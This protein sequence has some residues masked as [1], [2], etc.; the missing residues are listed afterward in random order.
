MPKVLMC[1]TS[2]GKSTSLSP[3]LALALGAALEQPQKTGEQMAE[4]F[5]QGMLK[6]RPTD[7]YDPI[8]ARRAPQHSRSKYMPH[9]GRRNRRASAEYA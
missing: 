6:G 9:S 8:P 3:Q 1:G 4:E 7:T 5:I 2:V